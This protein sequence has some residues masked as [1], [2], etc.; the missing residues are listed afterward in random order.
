MPQHTRTRN[1][2]RR[3]RTVTSAAAATAPN[4]FADMNLSNE[5]FEEMR[6]KIDQLTSDKEVLDRAMEEKGS[7]LTPDE[8]SELAPNYYNNISDIDSVF[9]EKTGSGFELSG[10]TEIA[11]GGRGTDTPLDQQMYGQLHS[12]QITD[13]ARDSKTLENPPPP[14]TQQGIQ[15]EATSSGMSSDKGDEASSVGGR[16]TGVVREDLQFPAA[17]HIP[18]K[19]LAQDRGVS[20][21][22]KDGNLSMQKTRSFAKDLVEE[23]YPENEISNL[24]D[25]KRKEAEK[26]RRTPERLI[27]ALERGDDSIMED[28]GVSRPTIYVPEGDDIPTTRNGVPIDRAGYKVVREPTPGSIAMQDIKDNFDPETGTYKFTVSPQQDVDTPYARKSEK[29]EDE[30]EQERDAEHRMDQ[31]E[32]EMQTSLDRRTRREVRGRVDPSRNPN[33]TGSDVNEYIRSRRDRNIRRPI[34]DQDENSG[35]QDAQQISRTR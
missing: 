6:G 21:T 26:L 8:V 5:E 13:L 7:A 9:R 19:Q 34:D 3:N 2:N 23:I 25:E 16:S 14:P 29:D 31:K 28:L 35:G 17:T 32:S 12:K 24:S 18:I 10:Q 4:V 11:S 15:M 30:L 22:D 20:I 33:P 1:N 27:S